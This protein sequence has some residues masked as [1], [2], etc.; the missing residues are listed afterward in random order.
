MCDSRPG[1]WQG[2]AFVL[3]VARAY[4]APSAA[5]Q[6]HAHTEASFGQTHAERAQAEGSHAVRVARSVRGNSKQRASGKRRRL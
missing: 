5:F 2:R 3:G 4:Q 6:E 1:G